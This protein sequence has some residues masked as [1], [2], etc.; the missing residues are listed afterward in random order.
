MTSIGSGIKNIPDKMR[1]VVIRKHG[2]PEVL[3]VEEI[4]IQQ[5]GL[6]EVLLKVEATALNRLDIFAR[7]G[8]SGPGVPLVTLPHVSGVDIVGRV[9]MYGPGCENLPSVPLIGDRVI[10]AP[11]VGC[12]ECR[13]C[14]LGEPSMCPNYKIIGEH[15][16]GGLADYVVVP[17]RNIIK[18]PDHIPSIVAASVPVVYTTAWRGVMTVAEV[19][20]SDVVLVVGASGGLGSA[21][22]EIAKAAGA[23]VIGTAS[24]A[25]KREKALEKGADLMLDSNSDWESSI[26]EWTNGRGVSAAFDSVGAPTIRH[27]LR[28][29][30]MN[31]KLILSGATAGDKPDISIREIYQWHRKIMG[32]PMGNWEDFLQVTSLVWQ[33]KLKPSI[34]AV[35]PLEEIAN[36]HVELE[37][38]NHFGKIVI[39]VND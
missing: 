37:K 9:A 17:A 33:E 11:A 6:G 14:R 12:N 36:A 13:Y 24:T 25:E 39:R 30:E 3:H 4:P 23:T 10:L 26:L 21:Q 16:W 20:P 34:H 38:R 15:C 5:P 31:G 19:K 7:K 1:A 22:V 2:G 29:L 32:A 8:L 18:I 28:S 35:F 27:S